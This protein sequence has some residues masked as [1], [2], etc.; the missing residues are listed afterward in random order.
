MI[1]D[2]GVSYSSLNYLKLFEIDGIKIDRSFVAQLDQE[3]GIKEYE[4]VKLI[5]SLAKKLELEVTA[6]G[7]ETEE[8]YRILRQLGCDEIQGYFFSRPM[9]LAEL[10]E[11]LDI[12]YTHQV[13][14]SR[15][16]QPSQL[17]NP[18][19]EEREM[20]RLKAILRL[21][22]LNTPQ[23]ERFD[24]ISRLVA[25]TFQDANRLHFHHDDRPTVVQIVCRYRAR[26]RSP[27]T[28]MDV[29]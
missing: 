3:S 7:V 20:Q 27:Q 14:L 29:M 25:Q 4:I 12:L 17:L 26:I 23:E 2:F 9:L 10:E 13:T 6:E 11:A 24:R 1:D 28:G 8:Q 19:L 22:I 21:E 18:S 16:D 15:I 5:V